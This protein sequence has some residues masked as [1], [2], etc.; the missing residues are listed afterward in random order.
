[1]AVLGVPVPVGREAL[2]AR[3]GQLELVAHAQVC[4]ASARR[5]YQLQARGTRRDS[6]DV[7]EGAFGTKNLRTFF[8]APCAR[9]RRV[10]GPGT[11]EGGAC[12]G[13]TGAVHLPLPVRL[14]AASVPTRGQLRRA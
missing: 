9:G 12:P 1:A 14:R 11:E 8:F 10:E 13:P 2:H 7:S 5:D 4:L 6:R 3:G